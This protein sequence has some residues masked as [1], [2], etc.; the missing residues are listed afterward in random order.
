M[1]CYEVI[2]KLES[3]SPAA[4]AEEWDNIGL[5][6][7]RRGKEVETI[8]IALDASDDVIEDAVRL[9]A[10]MLLTHHPLIFKK[11]DR[12]DTDDFIGKRVYELIR[13]DI[14]YY[15]MHTNFDVMGMADAAADELSL[16]DREVLN[17]TYEDDISKEGCGRIGRLNQCMSVAELAEL[18]KQRF[19][20]PN[21]RVYGDLGDIVEAAAVM[22]GSGG[23]YIKD[24]L[25]MG[26]DV[27]IT[28]DIDH[29]EGIDAVS[30]GLTLIDAGH[31]GIE[32]LFISYME[33]FIKREL[34]ELTVYKA[35]IKEP[36]VVV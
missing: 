20:V 13:N 26:A 30:Q 15:A 27:M 16:K 19:H 29:H 18:V 25:K 23:S 1:K 4:F 32:K 24:A 28:G 22:P 33:E 9:G 36:F 6:A 2:E 10:D 12:I 21:V 5:L 11:L 7:G 3:L 31:Y 34:P 8:Y 35:E 14:S 17:V